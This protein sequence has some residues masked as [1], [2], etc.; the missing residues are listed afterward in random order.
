[1]Q[2]LT[3]Y[4]RQEEAIQRMMAEPTQSILLASEQDQGKT[5]LSI[6]FALRMGFKRVLFI[7]IK[8]TFD[9]FRERAEAQSDGAQTIRR[10]DASKP[11]TAALADMEWGMEGWY[12]IGQ[13]LFTTRDWRNEPTGKYDNKGKEIQKAVQLHTWDRLDLDLIV[14]DEIHMAANHQSRGRKTIQAVHPEWKIAMSGT[15]YGN[16][17]D[18]AW[19][20]T[21]WLWPKII[22]RSYWAWRD[23]WCAEFEQRVKGG[24]TTKVVVGEKAPE[25]T[26]V[27]S[28]PCYI[29]HVGAEKVP[30]PTI[31]EVDLQPE[32]RRMY[33][34]LEKNLLV[35]KQDHPFI[36][37]WPVTL[38]ERLRTLALAEFD[39]I[40]ETQEVYLRD[41]AESTKLEALWEELAKY[42]QDKVVLGTHS[43][44]FAKFAVK[45]ML[46]KNLK[47]VEWSGDISSKGRE[48][49][50]QAWIADEI[51]YIVCVMK[52][53]STGLDWAQSNCWRMGVF[54]EPVGDP[55]VAGQWVRRVFRTGPHKD[56]FEWFK[57]QARSTFDNEEYM[58]LRLKELSQ[59]ASLTSRK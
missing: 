23:H 19:A 21:Q 4:P 3:P 12:F 20:P 31:I 15:F 32:Q 42:P 13:Q 53:F 59:Q 1:M 52:S 47:V 49:I 17:F 57:I 24:N 40:P 6:E 33:D 44:K 43:K 25:G 8:D 29:R 55:T 11:G 27:A 30:E 39:F 28:L 51:Q 41:D 14:Y 34:S 50:K 26:F 54:S 9:Q 56:K 22:P 7:G 37:E 10:I 2:K 18:N 46:K 38:K 45:R 5:L 36:I 35:W 58:A 48:E 16:K